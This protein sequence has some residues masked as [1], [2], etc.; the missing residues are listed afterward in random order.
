MERKRR[1]LKSLSWIPCS[2]CVSLGILGVSRSCKL[3]S[4]LCCKRLN[5]IANSAS[6]FDGLDEF[7]GDHAEIV[8][9][10]QLVSSFSHTKLCVS[11]RPLLVFDQALGMFPKLRLQDLSWTISTVSATYK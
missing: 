8:T 7:D 3:Y 5:A 6:S 1:F 11:S 10:F 9:F 2:I 4:R